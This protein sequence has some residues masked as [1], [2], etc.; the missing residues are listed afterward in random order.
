MLSRPRL[1]QRLDEAFGKR[2]T[3]IV[4]G[5]GFGKST[6]LS[7]WA[8]DVAAA[9]F[10][11]SASDTGL[12]MFAIG[13]MDTLRPLVGADD[14]PLVVPGGETDLARAEALAATISRWLQ[15][16]LEHDLM[17]VVDDAHELGSSPAALRLVESL[18]RQAPPT[19]HVVLATRE[20]LPLRTERLLAQGALLELTG[21]DLAFTVDEVAALVSA[22]LG[23][24]ASFADE[25]TTRSGGWPAAVRL[26]IEALR[27]VDD[28]DRPAA[29]ARL[30]EPGSPLF[31]YLAHEVFDCEP[32]ETI[33]L[34]RQVAL[35]DRFTPALC[36]ALGLTH[37]AEVLNELSRRGLFVLERDGWYALHD[38]MREFALVAWPLEDDERA[39]LLAAAAAWF[40]ESGLHEDALAAHASAHEFADVRG[41]IVDHG[42]ALLAQGAGD[43]VI[44]AASKLPTELRDS[45]IEIVAGD[46]HLARGEL[47]EAARCFERAG[48]GAPSLEA[49]VA[50][51]L[52]RACQMKGDMRAGLEICR[53]AN[54]DAGELRDRAC[55]NAWA[56]T[57]SAHLGALDD[58]RR[59]V[60]IALEQA[61]TSGDDGALADAHSA[62]QV[63]V[64]LEGGGE[65]G[66]VHGAA[67]LTAAEGS[68]DVYRLGRALVNSGVTLIGSGECEAGISELEKAIELTSSLMPDHQL[69][70]VGNRGHGLRMLGRFDEARVDYETLVDD[71]PDA[72][73]RAIGLIGVAEV[74]REQGNAE[75]ARDGYARGLALAEE[76]GYPLVQVTALC[77]LSRSLVDIDRAQA[78]R[79][80]RQA[81]G[82]GPA[83]Q[84]SAR[85]ALG[86]VALALGDRE[87]AARLSSEA[88]ELAR[89]ARV[90]YEVAE[91]FELTACA[92]S[93]PAEHK[94]HLEE[95]L[96]LWRELGNRVHVALCELALG[97]TASGPDAHRVAAAAERRLRGYGVRLNVAAPAGLL[98]E[99]APA[100]SAR[101]VVQTLG[102]FAVLRDGAPLADADWQSRKAR[103]LLKILV[104]RRG[105]ATPREYL[106]ETL[107]PDDDPS[108]LSNRL[109]VAMS[110]LRAVLD[111][112]KTV[113]ADA[114]VAATRESIALSRDVV[115]DIEIFVKE[116]EGGLALRSAGR[117][118]DAR[119]SL[120]HAESLYGGDFLDEDP[121]ADWAVGLREEARALYISVARALAE[122]ALLAG[123]ADRATR[124]FLRILGRDAYDEH[125]HLGLVSALELAGRHGEARRAYGLYVSRMEEIG[126]TPAT[127]PAPL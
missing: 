92:S 32:E 102:G 96:S 48:C 62:A 35:L 76:A 95:A 64:E 26:T 34:V 67:A 2:L 33:E 80:A 71:S 58:A 43:A 75:L 23:S 97:R 51:R 93:D 66:G 16:R 121:Y 56:A 86:W 89:E 84:T 126:T 88:R 68:G 37:A 65:E 45:E 50:W 79:R 11:A 6:L 83:G 9:W 40:A 1:E 122:D 4:A 116:A 14:N 30:R 49:R 13:L 46:A 27:Q 25:L 52:A 70:A 112:A 59:F 60:N 109:S 94:T 36:A 15:E 115:V 100:S 10:T 117:A 17:L 107:W 123:N 69:H 120:E 18:C 77:G 99:I 53:R 8:K 119:E 91:S 98:R 103:D 90:P 104:A 28:A 118:D 41:M 74:Q 125:A 106:M 110:T 72:L 12:S 5:A 47:D 21:A 78:D 42:E 108:R 54:A 19:L 127:F 22:S 39:E 20:V 24:D 73:H 55:L 124:S 57:C 113:T 82:L 81:V 63:T 38:L 114:F 101:L 111:P 61:H 105:R 87:Q 7:Q 29:L 31:S 44:D 85:S 3:T